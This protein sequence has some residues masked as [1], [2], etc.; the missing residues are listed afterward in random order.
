MPLLSSFCIRESNGPAED[1]AAGES[2]IHFK[3]GKVYQALHGKFSG[4]SLKS[5]RTTCNDV[6][7]RNARD[8]KCRTR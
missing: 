3:V 7:F 8:T 2:E 1:H 4:G 6:S 5:T